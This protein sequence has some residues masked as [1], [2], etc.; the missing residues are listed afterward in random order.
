MEDI[1]PV[2]N[3]RQQLLAS[4]KLKRVTDAGLL[5]EAGLKWL[6]VAADPWHDT[7]VSGVQGCPDTNTGKSVVAPANSEVQISKQ[8]GPGN[9]SVRITTQPLDRQLACN[10]YAHWG[11]NNFYS[12]DGFDHQVGSVTIEQTADTDLPFPDGFRRNGNAPVKNFVTT[13]EVPQKFRKG[14]FKVIGWGIE[15]INTT[16]PLEVQG[17]VTICRY[18]QNGAE[19]VQRYITAD[20]PTV[21]NNVYLRTK[22]VRFPPN[23]QTEMLQHQG[24]QQW[25]AKE[26][27][28]CVVPLK[29]LEQ[30]AT[31]TCDVMP[32]W[33]DDSDGL[34]EGGASYVYAQFLGQA[35]LPGMTVPMNQFSG[36]GKYIPSD[37]V[38][39][40]FNGLSDA[41]T[42]TV[43]SRWIIERFPSN[44]EDDILAIATPSAPFDPFALELYQR[45]MQKL[46][47]GVMYKENPGGEWFSRVLGE[48]A[49]LAAPVLSA[50]PHP[51]AQGAAAAITAGRKALQATPAPG[52]TIEPAVQQQ[53]QQQ[54][55]KQPKQRNR[56]RRPQRKRNDPEFD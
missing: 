47:P 21:T 23:S 56:Y 12:A 31:G 54:P 55:P 29:E 11:S 49:D 39:I 48:L 3:A 30:A 2:L 5:S 37:G 43:R 13:M 51:L 8:T 20:P 34:T 50:I 27:C 38:C 32:Q 42:L 45:V 1:S 6:T 35:T 17:L 16:S 44:D 9:W 28:Y 7:P 41:T 53:P 24:V 40:M 10:R 25:H 46:R 15:V 19:D 18:N 52:N 33:C 26:G 22:R 4:K 14:V 36:T